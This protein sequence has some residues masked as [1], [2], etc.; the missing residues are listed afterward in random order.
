[1]SSPDALD[2]EF[3]PKLAAVLFVPKR[4]LFIRGGRGSG[5]SWSV[6]RAL[7]LKAFAKP[8]RILC[9]REVQKSIKQSVH[10]LLKDQIAELGLNDF[11]QVLENEIRGLNGSA[12]YFS[13][14][15]DQTSTTIKSFEGCTLVW[16][17]E[18]QTLTQR[19]WRILTPTIRAANSEIWATYN[20]ELETDETHMMAVVNPPPDTISVEINYPDNPWFPAV[21]EAERKH[22]EATMRPDDYAHIWGGQ[23]KPAV[24]GAIYFESMSQTLAA[25]RIREVPHDA[26]LKTHVVF[27]LGMSDAMTLLLVQKVASEIRIIHYIEGTQR[28]LADYS[29]ELKALK[30]DDQPMN[31]GALYLPHD[32]FHVKHQTGK[33]DAT[34]LRGLGW[35][36]QAVPNIPVNTGIDRTRE[37][38]PRVYFH[39]SRTERLVECLKRYRW[40]INSKT[41][42]AVMPLHDEFS[43][44]ADGFRY[45]ALTESLMSNDEWGGSLKYPK[46]NNA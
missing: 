27:D 31:W 23:C 38:F 19:S 30:L 41:G 6:A 21:L 45:L 2:V 44:G 13:G 10:Q 46:S 17:E 8:E 4:Y 33:D 16:C 18:A 11:F 42:Q 5:K 32:G 20:P 40:N 29:S 36:V 24:E 39:Q 34:I 9:T 35:D 15:S 12:F 1:M 3:P 14:L 7:I 43:H 26:S 22:A 25:K 37:M 28:I